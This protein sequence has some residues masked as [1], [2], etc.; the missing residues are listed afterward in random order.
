ML[1]VEQVREELRRYEHPLL[2]FDAES[3]LHGRVVM[4]IALRQ[5]LEGVEPYRIVLHERDVAGTQFAWN[6]Q[7]LLYDCIH[8]FVAEMFIR[9]PQSR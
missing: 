8:D 2:S 4:Q 6:L 7:R 3:D 5:P 1:T 9:T